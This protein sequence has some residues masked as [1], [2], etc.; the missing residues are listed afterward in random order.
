[1]KL[2]VGAATDV[3]RIRSTNEDSYAARI[4]QGLFV[5]CDGM[6]GAAAGELASRIGVETIVDQLRDVRPD[7]SGARD[8]YGFRPHTVHLGEAVRH[9]NASIHAFAQGDHD[10]EG[11]GTTVVGIWLAGDVASIAHV[12]DSRA[13]LWHEGEFDALTVDHSVVEAQVRAGLLKREDSLRAA[14]QN[15]LLQALGLT[16]D[17]DVELGE[18][19]V[20]GGDYLLLCSDGLT[21]TVSDAAMGQTIADLKD[22]EAICRHLI[23]T[24]NTAGGPDNVTVVVVE[25]VNS[26]SDADHVAA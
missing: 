25:I 16:L 18:V 19:A 15:V 22:P 3:G 11:M 6:G 21:R 4:D 7:T 20:E 14:H 1:M 24:A 13:Y 26:A 2:R 9:A 10:R 23:D 8:A 5:I 12:G 17:V